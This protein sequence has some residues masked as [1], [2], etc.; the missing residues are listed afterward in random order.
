MHL[1]GL[2]LVVHFTPEPGHLLEKFLPQLVIVEFLDVLEVFFIFCWP[3]H[4]KTVLF[5]EVAGDQPPY[6][7]LFFIC[8]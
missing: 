8:I 4:C 3:D 5:F 1:L 6:F 2:D 7:V